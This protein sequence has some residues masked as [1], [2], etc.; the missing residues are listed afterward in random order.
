MM[1]GGAFILLN[2]GCG[3]RETA[4]QAEIRLAGL[5]TILSVL[6]TKGRKYLIFRV[7]IVLRHNFCGI[8]LIRGNRLFCYPDHSLSP[9]IGAVSSKDG[10]DKDMKSIGA[11]FYT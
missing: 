2:V 1:V 3:R 11:L 8:C 9:K 7:M 5:P 10:H 6:R 4:Y